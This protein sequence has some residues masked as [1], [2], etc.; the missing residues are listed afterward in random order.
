MIISGIMQRRRQLPKLGPRRQDHGSLISRDSLVISH[1]QSRLLPILVHRGA[2][3]IP[4][5]QRQRGAWKNRRNK[6]AVWSFQAGT[7]CLSIIVAVVRCLFALSLAYRGQSKAKK[8]KEESSAVRRLPLL[9]PCL[10][11]PLC[12]PLLRLLFGS[13]ALLEFPF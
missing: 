9:F 12:S 6:R 3:P 5:D 8:A 1:A 2:S 11:I 4:L 13:S 10:L 7:H